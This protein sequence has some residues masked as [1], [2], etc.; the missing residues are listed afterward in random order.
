[1]TAEIIAVGAGTALEGSGGVDLRILARQLALLGIE[2]RYQSRAQQREELQ[3]IMAAALKRS[4]VILTIGGM[5]GGAGDFT[6]EVICGG[7]SIPLDLQAET[8][9]HIRAY[10]E[11]AGLPVPP[12]AQRAAMLPRGGVEFQNGCGP[13]P[14]CAVSAGA[15]CILMLPGA[16]DQLFPMFMGGV[17]TYLTSFT[18]AEVYSR[19]ARIFGPGVQEVYE[20]LH[21]LVSAQNPTLAIYSQRGEIIARVTARANTK[22]Q[23]AAMCTPVLKEIVTGLGES[24]YGIDVDSLEAVVIAHLE[25]KK[26]S[27]ASGESGTD[28]LFSQRVNLVHGAQAV[29]RFGVTAHAN[30]IKMQALGVP[31]KIIKKF[32]PVSDRVAVHMASG[33]MEAGEADI[34][35]GVTAVSGRNEEGIPPG[36]VYIAV[37]NK[38]SVLVKRLALPQDSGVGVIREAAV[39]HALNLVRLLLDYDPEPCPGM[40]PLG[41]ALKGK[42]V[43]SDN[44]EAQ[45]EAQEE[46]DLMEGEP[47]RGRRRSLPG[48]LPERRWYHAF[49]PCEGDTG[50]DKFR[51][52]LLMLFLTVFVACCGYLGLKYWQSYQNEGLY[53]SLADIAQSAAEGGRD[54]LPEGYPSSYLPRFADLWEKNNDVKGWLSIDGTNVSYPVVQAD[55]N[56]FYLRRDFEKKS[57]D[58]GVP[59]LDFEVDLK[60]P[61]E[62]I[63][64]YGHNMKDGQMF[65]ELMGYKDAEYVSEHPI[66]E[67]DSVYRE[68][69][70]K[71]AGVFLASTENDHGP[72]FEYEKFVNSP[73]PEV[74]ESFAQ[75]VKLRSMVDTGVDIGQGDE[76]LCLSTCSYEYWEARFVVVARRLREGE[77]E[78]VNASD[79]KK[80]P[81]PLMPDV[82]YTITKTE[83]PAEFKNMGAWAPED[84]AVE[85]VP[86]GPA[87]PAFGSKEEPPESEGEQDVPEEE[88]ESTPASEPSAPVISASQTAASSSSPQTVSSSQASETL[89]PVSSKA[90][91]SSKVSSS[92]KA[93]SSSKASSSPKAESSS[94][95]AS[96][97]KAESSSKVSSS[98]KA[99][100]SSKAS[101]SSKVQS[102]SKSED[103]FEEESSSKVSSVSGG[104]GRLPGDGEVITID[105]GKTSSKSSGDEDEDEDVADPDDKWYSSSHSTSVALD[106]DGNPIVQN[107][108]SSSRPWWDGADDDDDDEDGE[109]SSASSGGEYGDGDKVTVKNNGKEVTLPFKEVVGRIVEVEM[110]RSFNEEA[111]K[112]QAV[113]AYTYVQ[114]YA[115][116]GQK[117]SVVLASGSVSSKVAKAVDAVFG[118]MIVYDGKPI[119][120]TYF[121]SCAG[122][123]NNSEDVWSEKLPYLRSVTSDENVREKEYTFKRSYIMDRL[124]DKLSSVDPLDYDED[125][126]FSDFEF[127]DNEEYV[128][129]L[130]ICGKKEKSGRWVR[131]ELLEYGIPSTAFDVE[132]DSDKERFI[133]TVRGNGHGVGMSQL[134]AQAMAENGDSY[135]DI[136]EH[137]YT[138]VRIR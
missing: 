19:V 62:N 71:V 113:A 93:E 2:L 18:G 96:L 41:A 70:Y 40:I 86:A 119:N 29:Y 81:S 77:S 78:D 31:E 123:T 37:C 28:G 103:A 27:M 52:V 56:D 106:F 131:E 53:K 49:L 73:S 32:G 84:V 5:E 34:G 69:K 39:L 87:G 61:S 6:K 85:N 35:V 129:K 128:D 80:N 72:I 12:E 90:E 24:V 138:N 111:L 122:A 89:T 55:D 118:K 99:E 125:E 10:Y 4:D 91:S 102:S 23:A 7:L 22:A 112:A 45:R 98:S 92:S 127:C 76:L 124:E 68:G 63:I 64:I 116:R 75:Q 120:A 117:A 51:K 3:Q 95:E 9:Q 8:Y 54:D 57:N 38:N 13:A 74:F 1:M 42:I 15:Q 83:K 130:K 26:M 47:K 25:Q 50:G 107:D 30:R 133:F 11:N 82:Y 137:Y 16:P 105:T 44:L 36:I 17:F 108:N 132:Y 14:G 104:N 97:S 109:D 88:P 59:F 66:I 135:E 60:R 20:K 21:P 110:G 101:S 114:Y 65:G 79:Y 67:F 100:S 126:W 115:V 121:A 33:A 46:M 94:K 134:G 58:H 43:L 48:A 136:L